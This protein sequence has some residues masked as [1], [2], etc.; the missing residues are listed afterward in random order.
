ML[1][2]IDALNYNLFNKSLLVKEQPED[3]L[4]R[5]RSSYQ[6]RGHYYEY[7]IVLWLSWLCNKIAYTLKDGLDIDTGPW[8]LES[9]NSNLHE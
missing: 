7:K 8:P 1:S 3:L 9:E 4:N 6:Y 2:L 5:K